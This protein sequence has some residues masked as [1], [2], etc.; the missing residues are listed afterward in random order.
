MKRGKNYLDAVKMYDK[1]QQYDP[2]EAVELTV[3]MAKAKFD[4]TVEAHIKLGVDSRHADQQVRGA[5]VLPHGTG[6]T[7]RVLVFAKGDKLAEA[8]AAGADFVGGEELIPKIQNDNWFDYDIIV[9][10]PDMMGVV[11]RLGKVLGPKGLMPNPK[12]GTVTMD[13]TKA[14]ND[15]K[16]GKIEYRLDKTNIIHCPVGK[17]SFGPDKL[18][19]N[20]ETLMN[21][22]V[23]AKPAAAKGQYLK[24]VTVT[25]TMGPGVKV[26]TA[27]LMG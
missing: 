2:A 22:I 13:V 18:R 11:G 20:F 21:A 16:A 1:T 17:V 19:E 7:V 9:A 23:K 15:I 27:K 3:K 8:E 25:S 5:V 26:N 4:E 12:A 14:I 10:T 6:K 24:S